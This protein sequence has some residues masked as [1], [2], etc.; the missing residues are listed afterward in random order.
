[1]EVR[2]RGER[3]LPTSAIRTPLKLPVYS[4]PAGGVVLFLAFARA[5]LRLR[6]ARWGVWVLM[7]NAA[8]FKREDGWVTQWSQDKGL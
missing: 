4:P 2:K 3:E 7:L 6:L 8:R 5:C 1:M